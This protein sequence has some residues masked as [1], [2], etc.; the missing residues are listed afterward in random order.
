MGDNDTGGCPATSFVAMRRPRYYW[1]N[2]KAESY[3]PDG[4]EQTER[5]LKYVRVWK[6]PPV[7]SWLESFQLDVG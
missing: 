7:E 2:W 1:L 5:Y 3:D 4:W 6:K